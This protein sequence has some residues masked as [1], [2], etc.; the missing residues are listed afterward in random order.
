VR[1][2]DSRAYEEALGR[3]EQEYE[4]YLDDSGDYADPD[5]ADEL[6]EDYAAR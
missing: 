4:D 2:G 6:D 1:P 3:L 5:Y